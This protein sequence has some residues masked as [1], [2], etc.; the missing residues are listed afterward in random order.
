MHAAMPWPAIL[1]LLVQPSRS[2]SPQARRTPH[3]GYHGQGQ[4]EFFEGWYSRVTLP[5]R[6]VV[7]VHLRDL[8]SRPPDGA[9]GRRRASPGVSR[10]TPQ[11]RSARLPQIARPSPRRPHD[12]SLRYAGADFSFAMTSSGTK[13]RLDGGAWTPSARTSAG[14]GASAAA[15][16]YSTAGWLAALGPLLS[17]HY[18]VLMSLGHATGWVEIEDNGR[19][20]RTPRSTPEKNWGRGFPRKW[21]W[22]QCNAFD[23]VEPASQLTLTATARAPEPAGRRGARARGGRRAGG[24]SF[25]RRVLALPRGRVDRGAVG[26]VARDRVLRRPGHVLHDR[27]AETGSRAARSA[28]RRRAAWSTARGRRTAARCA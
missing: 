28:S 23:D 5:E 13:G 9:V 27:G 2:L 19:R 7:R 11:K 3:A 15:R 4:I 26:R 1:L 25:G 17:P 10:R 18:Q 22:L 16:R 8:R 14:A 12:L 24:H 21:W 20:S 6:P